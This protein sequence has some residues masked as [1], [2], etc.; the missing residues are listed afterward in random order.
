MKIPPLLAPLT[1]ALLLSA[2]ATGPQTRPALQIDSSYTSANQDSR[3]Q[4]LI[5]HYTVLDFPKSLKVLTSGGMVSSHYLV[6]DEPPT[7]YRL[8][9][10]SRRAFHAG[11]S[12]WRGQTGLNA[13]SVGIEIVN[14]GIVDGASRAFVPEPPLGKRGMEARLRPVGAGARQVVRR[15]H[16]L[17]K[18]QMLETVQGIVMNEIANRRLCRQNVRQM[19]HPARQ[20][21]GQ[22][23]II[24]VRQVSHRTP[25][26]VDQRRQRS[27]ATAAP[28]RCPG[29]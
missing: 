8:V 13:S 10:E 3:A 17:G 28:A 16:C 15:R 18:G 12:H 29:K 24:V 5:L 2:C 22:R 4:F 23:Q 6:R 14:A 26:P 25:A 27:G 21:F 20:A 7:I 9:D 1:L 11:V 19:G